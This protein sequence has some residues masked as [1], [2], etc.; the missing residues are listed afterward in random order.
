MATFFALSIAVSK[1][2]LGS[3]SS[4]RYPSKNNISLFFTEETSISFSLIFPAVPRKVT[5]VLSESG[6]T[7]I[8]QVPVG[9]FSFFFEYKNLTLSFFKPFSYLLPKSSSLILPIKPTSFPSCERPTI[10]FA[11]EPPDTV[12]SIFNED[13]IFLNSYSSTSFIVL[14]VR[15][16]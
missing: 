3:P 7:N 5:I 13:N 9:I 8:K 16:F 11:T 10:V 12:S 15:L 14:F 1:A 2:F 4:Q 6:V